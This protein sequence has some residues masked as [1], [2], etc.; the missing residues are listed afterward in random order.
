MLALTKPTTMLPGPKFE[1]IEA[2][3]AAFPPD[4]Q[5]KLKQVHRAVL[6]GAPKAEP[7]IS[8][9]MPAFKLH[10]VLV[11]YAA[12]KNHI[13]FYPTA[14]GIASFAEELKDYKTSKGAIQ[15]PM[16]QPIPVALVKK[17]TAFRREEN[18]MKATLKK[19]KK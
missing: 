13:G 5:Q 2:Y 19:K 1:S 6:A 7:C 16:D 10:G 18:E 17:I 3:H 14:S 8:Y 11:Y 4:I 9:N 15:F 12:F